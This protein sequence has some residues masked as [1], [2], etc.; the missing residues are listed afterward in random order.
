MDASSVYFRN[1]KDGVITTRK[2]G[3]SINHSVLIIGYGTVGNIDYWI[4]KNSFGKTWGDS[5]FARIKRDPN[6]DACA[7]NS[8]IAYP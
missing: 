3:Q 7:I 5:G 1:Y 2:C 6:R 8:Y 4:I